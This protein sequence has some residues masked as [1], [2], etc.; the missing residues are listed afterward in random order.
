MQPMQQQPT[1]EHAQAEAHGPRGD[2]ATRPATDSRG[3]RTPRPLL[4]SAGIALAQLVGLAVV[5]AIFHLHT[6]LWAIPAFLPMYG[7]Y[8]A[9]AAAGRTLRPDALAKLRRQERA[10]ATAGALLAFVLIWPSWAAPA[11]R[12]W[13]GQNSLGLL[14]PIHLPSF[15]YSAVLHAAPFELG[16]VSLALVVLAMT[17]TPSRPTG[18]T[19]EDLPSRGT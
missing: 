18:S 5:F 1:V 6:G 4:L 3:W 14:M 11:H 9:S 16:L 7:W 2:A 19:A 12:A 17:A 13:E 15:N 10:A 8:L